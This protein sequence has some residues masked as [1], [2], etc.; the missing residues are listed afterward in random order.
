MTSILADLQQ[1]FE[2]EEDEDERAYIAALAHHYA[3]V[4]TWLAVLL[5]HHFASDLSRI[6][7]VAIA[8]S[9]WLFRMIVDG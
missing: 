7:Q 3:K 8:W 5:I 9:R 6:Q 2:L 4:S 1:L